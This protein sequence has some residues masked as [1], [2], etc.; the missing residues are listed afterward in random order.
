MPANY[1]NELRVAI[2]AVRTAARVCRSVQ[3]KITPDVMQK[4]DRSPVTVADFASQAVIC[5]AIG[6][7][8]PADP[9]IGEEESSTLRKEEN[10]PFLSRILAELRG[11]G[12]ETC[13]KEACAWIDRASQKTY[14]PRFWTL[15]PIDG[16]KGFLRKEQYAISVALVI[17]GQIQLALLGCPNLPCE[18]SGEKIGTLLYAIRGKGSWSLPLEDGTYPQPVRASTVSDPK[19]AR[20]CESVEAAHTAHGLAA[21]VAA[22]LGIVR[23]PLRLD[24]QAKYAVVARGEAEIYLRLPAKFGYKE[25]I[26][27]HAGGV[28]IVEEAGGSVCDVTGK[29]LEFNHGHELSANRGVVAANRPLHPRVIEALHEIYKTLPPAQQPT[30]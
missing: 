4:D 20:F 24:S 10:G 17:E 27:D 30:P 21:K 5:R 13:G 7:A 8:F 19:Q 23:E 9:I 18:P 2:E 22:M 1:E 26:W 29:P 14:V 28:L 11:V 6:A 12:I 15:D 16:T 3:E 25:K